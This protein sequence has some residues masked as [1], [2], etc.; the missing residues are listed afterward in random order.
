M[1][2]K[3]TDLYEKEMVG[4][5]LTNKAVVIKSKHLEGSKYIVLAVRKVP[6]EPLYDE[7][8]VEK[9]TPIYHRPYIVWQVDKKTMR[10]MSGEYALTLEEA[11]EVYEIY[12]NKK[13][14]L[15]V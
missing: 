7:R 5:E 15:I 1:S 14:F 10:P 6:A 9:T 2:N 12:G 13:K 4:A 11:E 3:L 8:D